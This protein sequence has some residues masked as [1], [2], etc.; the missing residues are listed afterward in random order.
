MT[1]RR[2]DR[3][4]ERSRVTIMVNRWYEEGTHEK[5]MLK[6][7]DVW[8]RE[9]PNITTKIGLLP[10]MPPH[11]WT[12]PQQ[13]ILMTSTLD[14]SMR[15]LFKPQTNS[16]I[17]GLKGFTMFLFPPDYPSSTSSFFPQALAV[18]A[19][20]HY[21]VR[22]YVCLYNYSVVSFQSRVV[23]QLV[24]VPSVSARS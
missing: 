14:L 13:T 22:M 15:V 1:D 20:F 10:L 17:K 21:D 5:V 23:L 9:S 11:S 3:Q 6:W 19:L 12:I 24:V 7:A 8:K 4:T 16:L 2:T 18:T